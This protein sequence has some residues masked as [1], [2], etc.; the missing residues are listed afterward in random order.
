MTRVFESCTVDGVD[1]DNDVPFTLIGALFNKSNEVYMV[2]TSSWYSAI[3]PLISDNKLFLC[4]EVAPACV[5][6]TRYTDVDWRWPFTTPRV[7]ALEDGSV[8]VLVNASRH[9]SDK[10]IPG[11]DEIVH[12]WRY[13]FQYVSY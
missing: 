9:A 8:D 4:I 6:S 5:L 10:D 7:K 3:L 13:S 12:F 1:I 11:N 2:D